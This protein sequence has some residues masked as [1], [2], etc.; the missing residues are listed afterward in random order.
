MSLYYMI[1]V[2]I[3]AREVAFT[4]YD[5]QNWCKAESVTP[6]LSGNVILEW[7]LTGS[8]GPFCGKKMEIYLAHAFFVGLFRKCLHS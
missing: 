2:A 5:A 1:T 8:K 3:L 4:I 7:Q 6:K